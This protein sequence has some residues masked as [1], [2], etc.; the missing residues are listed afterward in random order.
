MKRPL[1]VNNPPAGMSA[2]ELAVWNSSNENLNE[3]TDVI[4]KFFQDEQSVRSIQPSKPVPLG[5]IGSAPKPEGYINEWHQ[6]NFQLQPLYSNG[7]WKVRLFAGT[8]ALI[9]N[10][11]A[12]YGS[13]LS[14]Q[15]SWEAQ[16][17][18]AGFPNYV[19]DDTENDKLHCVITHSNQ[20]EGIKS[21]VTIE[22]KS[23]LS[24]YSGY[25]GVLVYTQRDLGQDFI[26]FRS[27]MVRCNDPFGKFPQYKQE[28]G[29]FAT[30]GNTQGTASIQLAIPPT[31]NK[32][33]NVKNRGW[34]NIATECQNP[35]F[36]AQGRGFYQGLP[37]QGYVNQF[38][39]APQ[40]QLNFSRWCIQDP[41]FANTVGVWSR[42]SSR[43]IGNCAFDPP[44]FCN[45]VDPCY[46][47]G[48]F[49][50]SVPS[51]KSTVLESEI[52]PFRGISP[53]EAEGDEK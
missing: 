25:E 21:S 38:C 50:F 47:P 48:Y 36:Q 20:A 15:P 28:H 19:H 29:P 52:T 39:F 30:M 33:Q 26:P 35:A 13:F 24:W 32:R 7:Q 10:C 16:A 40:I 41:G 1:T 34:M 37:V 27:G 8:N 2:E 22:L 3:A 31:P 46:L 49:D 53:S 51:G 12:T 6:L 14:T 42:N 5:N 23:L 11:D 17:A 43:T 4:E 44:T 18:A 9:R 45:D